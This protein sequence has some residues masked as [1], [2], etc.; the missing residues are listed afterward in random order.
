MVLKATTSFC[1]YRLKLCV[2]SPFYW[3]ETMHYLDSSHGVGG[4]GCGGGGCVEKENKNNSS[5]EVGS[6]SPAGYN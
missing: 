1:I 6:A 3:I 4:G 5:N 2:H